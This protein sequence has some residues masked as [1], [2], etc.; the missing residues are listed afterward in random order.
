MAKL[1]WDDIGERIY[2]TG[3]KHGV[4]YLQV[5]KAYPKGVA[6]NGLTGVSSEPDGGDAE[7]IYADDIK[8]LS[9]RAR[10]DFG[11]TIT[12][13]TYPD[14]FMECDG[15]VKFGGIPGV[16]VGQQARKPFGF[17]YTTTVGND[18][19]YEDYGYKLHL[20]YG[21]TASPSS[22]D[23]ATM[24]DSPEAIEFSWDFDTVPVAMPFGLKPS[25]SIVIDSTHFKTAAEK[26]RLLALE[27]A[28]FGTD[29]QEATEAVY[30]ATTDE[31][32]LAGKTYYTKSGTT[33][34]EFSGEEFVSGTTY[35]EMV[36]PAM[37]ATEAHDPY[38]PLPTEVYS[39]LNGN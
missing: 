1:I 21:A 34:T 31:T 15:T 16:F 35:Y 36:S 37:P 24:N 8:Y 3:T 20:I 23:Y 2:E 32:P 29:A 10:E 11:G 38:L 13:Y 14:E 33:Y 12:A 9:I 27:N 22:R 19:E 30:E 5:G 17:C 6:W 7:E 39:I 25:A 18:V 28:L 26:E 4:L